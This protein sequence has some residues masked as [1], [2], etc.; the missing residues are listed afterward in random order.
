[1]YRFLTILILAI[2]SFLTA[3]PTDRA[4]LVGIGKYDRLRTGWSEIHGD[5]DVELL[6]P[7]LRKQGFTDITV[8]TNGQATK[9]AIVGELK[10]LADRCKAGD[11]VYFHFSGHGQPIRDDNHDESDNKPYDE[12]IIP[13]DAC[14]DS[15]KMDGK[16]V[17]Q[18][19]LIDDELCPLLD[20]IKTRIGKGGELFVA[21][22]AC[23][24]KGIQKDEMTDTDPDLLRY[25][26]GTNYAFTPPGHSSYLARLPKPKRFSPGARLTVVTACGNKERN[27]EYKS[28]S[29]KMYGSLTFYIAT[30]LKS[31]AD[32]SHWIRCFQNKAYLS[33]GIFQPIQHPSITVYD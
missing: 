12:S 6:V 27:F 32:F 18:Y 24:S 28:A 20:S 1:M 19:H 9:A 33:R 13:Y 7:L 8:L 3:R 22:D 25:V 11:K 21:I 10:K 2:F 26:R 17:G 30:L 14:R 29:G 5:N 4:L 31:D 15:R 23:Y 16:Y